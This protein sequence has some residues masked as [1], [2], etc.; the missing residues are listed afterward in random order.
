MISQRSR[1]VEQ[2]TVIPEV[3]SLQVLVTSLILSALHS[4][5]THNSPQALGT[6]RIY[7]QVA[8]SRLSILTVDG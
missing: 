4:N 6:V 5:A 2:Q 8:L 7:H 1:K 3:I